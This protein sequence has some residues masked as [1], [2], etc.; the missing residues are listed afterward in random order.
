MAKHKVSE[1][2][3]ALLDAAVALAE[4]MN[5]VFESFM[6][7]PPRPA[8]CWVVSQEMKYRERAVGVLMVEQVPAGVVDGRRLFNPSGTWEDGGP[9]IERE[10]IAPQPERRGDIGN[11]WADQPEPALGWEVHLGGRT[12]TGPTYLI[13]AMRAFCA[14]RFGEFVE[15]P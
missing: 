5:F 7:N 3:G 15:L 11:E 1:L 10:R 14:S 12:I 4:G 9:I 8:A 6:T 2:E 13:T